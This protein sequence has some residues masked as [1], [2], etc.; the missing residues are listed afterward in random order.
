MDIKHF[1]SYLILFVMMGC[2]TTN[3]KKEAGNKATTSIATI[4]IEG[5]AC[6]EGCADT[7]QQNLVEL[8]GVNSAEVSFDKGTA[9]VEFIPSSVTS[10]EIQKSITDTKVKDYVYTIKDIIIKNKPSK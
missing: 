6:Q 4:N 1:F 7:I 2:A 10:K 3:V 5:M 9:V 8:E